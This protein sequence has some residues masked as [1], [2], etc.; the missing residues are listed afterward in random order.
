MMTRFFSTGRGRQSRT[1]PVRRGRRAL[2]ILSARG[3]GR[4]G[5]YGLMGCPGAGGC[6]SLGGGTRHGTVGCGGEI[7]GDGRR[8]EGGGTRLSRGAMG[9]KE[10]GE[11]RR[12]EGQEISPVP[13]SVG[14]EGEHARAGRA[15]VSRSYMIHVACF[16]RLMF[17]SFSP[18]P[19]CMSDHPFRSPGPL[20]RPAVPLT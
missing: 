4:T 13:R 1:K 9:E 8:S 6:R 5:R 7:P 12:K 14:D 16:V 11:K 17:S 18:Q 3:V 10:R 2:S 15:F 19:V 20:T